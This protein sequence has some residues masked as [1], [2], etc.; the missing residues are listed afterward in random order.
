MQYAWNIHY[1]VFTKKDSPSKLAK[2]IGSLNGHFVR[3]LE[4]PYSTVSTPRPKQRPKGRPRPLRARPML[5]WLRESAWVQFWAIPWRKGCPSFSFA[6][7]KTDFDVTIKIHQENRSCSSRRCSL[8]K[9]QTLWYM[10]T[11]CWESTCS[12]STY[13]ILQTVYK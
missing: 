7:L 13:N 2:K 1:H 6:N 10:W 4:D 11:L 8:P 12:I 9:K 5:M 3:W